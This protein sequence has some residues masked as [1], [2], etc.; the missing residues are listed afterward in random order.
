MKKRKSALRGG[1]AGAIAGLAASA[2]ISQF[3]SL[4]RKPEASSRQEDSTVLAA[5][6]VSR[7]ALHRDLSSGEK[8]IA[9]PLVHYL[10]GAGLATAY[11]I[12]VEMFPEFPKAWGVPFGSAVWLGAHVIAVPALGLSKSILE[13][14]P[15]A[16]AVEF[17]AHLVYGAVSEELRRFL[18]NRV[19]RS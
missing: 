11:G 16:E 17:C 2:A 8:K 3:H 4:F 13:S 9:G 5:S 10:F 1:I 18:R 15:R 14:E 19:L 6:A 7:A 12:A